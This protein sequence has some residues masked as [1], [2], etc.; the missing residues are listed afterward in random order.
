MFVRILCRTPGSSP[1][2]RFPPTPGPVAVLDSENRFSTL[3]YLF[4]FKGM[5][6]ITHGS[7]VKTCFQPTGAA[8]PSSASPSAALPVEVVSSAT[9][10][11]C[12]LMSEVVCHTVPPSGRAG[13]GPTFEVTKLVRSIA[14]AAGHVVA[15]L[16]PPPPHPPAPSP[17]TVPAGT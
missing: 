15:P 17:A 6:S 10:L 2:A 12:T 11:R 16:T 13:Y 1:P 9:R 8:P 4:L 14:E 3:I 7:K 5:H